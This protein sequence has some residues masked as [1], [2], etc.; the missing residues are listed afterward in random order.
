MKVRLCLE[1][2]ASL[3]LKSI[4]IKKPFNHQFIPISQ[5]SGYLLILVAV[6]LLILTASSA[7]FFV[8]QTD[9]IRS[10]GALRDSTES[11]MLAETAMEMLRGQFIN[12][13]DTVV[14]TPTD[15][16]D[17]VAAEALAP[18]IATPDGSLFPYM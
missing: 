11:L 3:R 16:L 2:R 9:N 18:N 17:K 12:T 15:V 14:E 5:Q 4:M 6:F 10:S 1:I 7:Q 13:L 8:R